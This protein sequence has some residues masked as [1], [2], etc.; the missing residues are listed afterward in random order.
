MVLNNRRE[1]EIQKKEIDNIISSSMGKRKSSLKYEPHIVINLKREINAM[2][3]RYEALEGANEELRKNI[4]ATKIGELEADIQEYASE[5]ERLAKIVEEGLSNLPDVSS[6]QEKAYAELEGKF[7]AKLTEITALNHS[8]STKNNEIKGL[9]EK[10]KQQQVQCDNQIARIKEEIQKSQRI[11]ENEISSLKS[12]INE[13]KSQNLQLT[14]DLST[15]KTSNNEIS[16]KDKELQAKNIRYEQEAKMHKDEISKHKAQIAQLQNN[17]K[18]FAEKMPKED[19][20]TKLAEQQMKNK[21]LTEQL[22]AANT[23]IEQCKKSVDS[24]FT[25]L[26][27]QIT[28][29]MIIIQKIMKLLSSKQQSRK[30]K[31]TSKWKN[32]AYPKSIPSILS[33]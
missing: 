19:V 24:S 28:N 11:F 32:R 1:A 22:N 2:K 13:Y 6:E 20:N 5:C 14:K 9:N 25:D 3:E 33:T 30:R 18:D 15:H 16:N 8:M 21:E 10:I 23:I 27:A 29:S 12:Q 7:R 4:K 31:T 26:K 17:I